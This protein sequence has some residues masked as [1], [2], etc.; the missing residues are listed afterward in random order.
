G[1]RP[2]DLPFAPGPVPP[3]PAPGRA[4]FWAGIR[5]LNQTIRVLDSTRGD[6]KLPFLKPV[7]DALAT[8]EGIKGPLRT[9]G[10]IDVDVALIEQLTGT[11][12]LTQEAHGIALRA[13]L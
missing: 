12:T 9:F 5:G 10:G 1:L 11:T 13:E 3:R 8:L 7:T 4:R 6:L 2:E